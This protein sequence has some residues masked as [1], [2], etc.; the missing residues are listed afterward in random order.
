MKTDYIVFLDI[1]GVFTSERMHFASSRN[2]EMW[3]QFDPVAVNFMNKIHL[4]TTNIRFVLSSTWKSDLRNDCMYVEHFVNSCF[5]NAGFIGEFGKPWKTNPDNL[6]KFKDRSYE[7]KEYLEI[8]APECKDYI[9]FD[10]VDYNFKDV[11]GKKRL[12]KTSGVDGLLNKHMH[13]AFSMIGHWG[14]E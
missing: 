13:D 7:I 9:I 6:T 3:S 11:L 4:K 10:D 2:A 1:D 8:F 12:I 5:R 14:N